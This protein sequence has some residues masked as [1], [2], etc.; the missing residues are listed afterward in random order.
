LKSPGTPAGVERGKSKISAD[1]E[2]PAALKRT[3]AK[4]AVGPKKVVTAKKVPAKKA[5]TAKKAAAKKPAKTDGYDP[6]AK[7]VLLVKEN[8]RREGTDVYK[9]FEL[10]K[11]SK[12]VGDF[13]KAGGRTGTLRKSLVKK[14]A[15]LA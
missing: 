6:A 2:I 4:I 9:Q 7:I 14:W 5:A 10:M 1:L 15:K 8:P 13:W 11:K 12:T 3:E